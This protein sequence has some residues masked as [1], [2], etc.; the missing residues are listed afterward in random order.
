MWTE[1]NGQL[2]EEAVTMRAKVAD[3]MTRAV[4]AVHR[5]ATFKEIAARLQDGH[6]SAVPVIDEDNKVIGVV[7]A[8]DLLA[9]EAVAGDGQNFTGP[10]AGLLHRQE[11]E[12]ARGVT[13]DELMTRPPVTVGPDDPISQAAQLMYDR[14][15]KRLPVV[16]SAGRLAGIVSRT[17]IL[18]VFS[19]PDEEIHKQITND[20][21]LDTYLMNPLRFRVTVKDGVVT[22]SG[23]PESALVGHEIIDTIRHVEGVVAVRDRLDYPSGEP[24]HSY[25]PLF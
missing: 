1:A 8:A 20:V 11:L 17:D 23:D 6:I 24:L 22:M 19:R 10:L 5:G 9:K 21:I 4:I 25:G 18:G 14:R 12:K 16:D 15:V 7:S 13:A 2:T 3:I